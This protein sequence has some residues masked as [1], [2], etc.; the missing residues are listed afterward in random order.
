MT[1][2]IDNKPIKLVAFK[3]FVPDSLR[4]WIY[5]F[6]AFIIQSSGGIYLAMAS[7][8]VGSLGLMQ[9]DIMFAGYASFIGM[10]MIFPLLFPIKF[11]FF[12]K[13]IMLT[14][15]FGLIICNLISMSTRSL[16]VLVVVC[17]I[18]GICRMVSF[19]E[20][21]STIQLKITPTRDFAKFFPVV[22]SLVLGCIQFSGILAGYMA[23]YYSWQQMHLL[24]AGSLL[25]VALAILL[26][27]KPFRPQ[28]TPMPPIKIDFLGAILWSF[29]LMLF[30]FVLVYGEHYDWLHSDYIRFSILAALLLFGIIVWRAKMLK[31]YYIDFKVFRQKKVGTMLLLFTAMCILLAI[32][33]VVQ[34]AY[35]SAILHYDYLHTLSLNWGVVAGLI[36]GALFSSWALVKMNMSFKLVTSVGFI[37]ILFYVAQMYFLISQTT[38]IEMFYLPMFC[39]GAANMIIYVSLTTYAAR[40]IP[41]L[42]FFQALTIFGFIRTG[43]GTPLGVA[44]VERLFLVCEKQNSL[45]LGAHLDAVNPVAQNLS[46]N[47]IVEELQRQVMLVS[48]KEVFGFAVIAAILIL[49]VTLAARYKS[50]LKF[51]MPRWE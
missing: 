18:A 38:S 15:I 50:W 20:C 9:E 45:S 3:D 4:F 12:Q 49:L 36:G 48:V 8:M 33:N 40:V 35:T 30:V 25:V 5:I 26:L 34:N 6:Y 37:M 13:R 27:M 47:V 21:M 14:G 16:P 7:Q 11:R 42:P 41:F 32:P 51:K 1:H 24:I 46:F 23:Y 29:V 2:A 39:R 10:T 17:F 28:G 43:I 22:Y 19:F 44:I 31:R